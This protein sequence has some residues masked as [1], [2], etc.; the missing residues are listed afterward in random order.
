[1][2]RDVT[3][4]EYVQLYKDVQSLVRAWKDRLD[5]S[6]HDA[7]CVLLQIG[8]T[9]AAWSGTS[10]E[11]TL[12]HVKHAWETVTDGFDRA[13]IV[14]GPVSRATALRRELEIRVIA[15]QTTMASRIAREAE[16][17]REEIR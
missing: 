1:M 16:E 17:A 4:S 14:E 10:L 8:G 3:P 15:R 12:T 2:S 5:I 6:E 13:H 7:S 11:I 9:M